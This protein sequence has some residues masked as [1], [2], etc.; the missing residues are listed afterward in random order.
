MPCAPAQRFAWHI[1]RRVSSFSYRL[2]PYTFGRGWGTMKLGGRLR[3]TPGCHFA[4][5][6][7]QCCGA[8]RPWPVFGWGCLLATWIE[9]L[10]F[11]AYRRLATSSSMGARSGHEPAD[12]RASTIGMLT[13]PLYSYPRFARGFRTFC[14]RRRRLQPASDGDRRCVMPPLDRVAGLAATCCEDAARGGKLG[15]AE[16]M[17]VWRTAIGMR[18]N[19]DRTGTC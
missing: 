6:L 16:V 15:L 10:L 9:W 8:V 7:P 17:F 2:A 14:Q 13:P 11:A 1:S 19:D 12:H 4:R 18:S 3:C 5:P